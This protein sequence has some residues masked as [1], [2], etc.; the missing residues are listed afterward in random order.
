MSRR[1]S[2][3]AGRIILLLAAVCVYARLYFGVD[4]TDEA[5]YVGLPYSFELGHR[6]LVDEVSVHQLGGLVLQ[7]FTAA[8]LALVGSAA[9][10]VLAARHLYFVC[11]LASALLVRGYLSEI[12]SERVGNLAAALSLS[13]IAFLIPSLSYNTISSFGLLS[14]TVLLAW[15]LLPGRGLV[16]LV[17]LAIGTA[18]LAL[19]AF[20]YPPVLIVAL[21]GLTLGLAGFW[22]V[23]DPELRRKA[24][25]VVAITGGACVAIGLTII[26]RHGGLDGIARVTELSQALDVQGGGSAKLRQLG[27]EI[28]GEAPFLLALLGLV[29]A[30]ALLYARASKD[31]FLL[32][33]GMGMLPALLAVDLLYRPFNEPYSSASFALSACGLAAPLS[34]WALRRDL[35]RR[36]WL[37]LVC[38]TLAS[39]VAA[40]AILWSSANGLRNAALGLLPAALIAISSLP[41]HRRRWAAS[42]GLQGNLAH[43]ILVTSLVAFQILQMWT[44]TYGDFAMNLLR[45]PIHS[46]AWAGIRTTAA[47]RRFV[48]ELESDLAG[49]RKGAR[50][51]IFFDYFPGGYLM[52]DLKP[53]TPAIWLFPPVRLHWGNE[54]ARAL[55]AED[56]REKR[57]LPDLVVR[58]RCVPKTG[59]ITPL[60]QSPNDPV[61]EALAQG[62]YEM[63]VTRSC[64]TIARR[65]QAG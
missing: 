33:L 3:H 55:Y 53:R 13:Y 11:S 54:A 31:T 1:H 60:P 57:P 15:A 35:E 50:T 40:L 22:H 24:L 39:Q 32:A 65:V 48:E 21:L 29:V 19:A 43:T 45:V 47:R 56:L 51:V 63:I 64:Y 28:L 46:G 36:Q 58:M 34:V 6:P 18:L 44:H 41:T 62:Q 17:Q 4:F 42:A 8:Y 14:G 25:L 16:R 20:A 10:L 49:A 37:G 26:V 7:P 23:C 52:S 2:D 61:I 5:F 38:I 59:R 30:T 27:S 9:G 12:F